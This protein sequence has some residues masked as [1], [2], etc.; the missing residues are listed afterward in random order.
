VVHQRLLLAI[1]ASTGA[2]FTSFTTTENVF[3]SLNG[4]VP[5]SVT[6]TVMEFVDG[7]CASVDVHEKTPLT[8]WIVALVGAPGQPKRICA[9][10]HSTLV[11]MFV[12]L[13]ALYSFTVFEIANST[14]GCSSH[15]RRDRQ[16]TAAACRRS[17]RRIR[18]RDKAARRQPLRPRR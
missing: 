1:A 18:H 13:C 14:S 7:P 11:V 3:V 9:V 12:K 17:D 15:R 2:T 8:G 5:L 4:G 16:S 10:T 6:R